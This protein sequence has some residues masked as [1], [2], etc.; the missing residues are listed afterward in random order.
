MSYVFETPRASPADS[1]AGGVASVEDIYAA[2]RDQMIFVDNSFATN[3]AMERAID[4]RNAEV[5][6]ATGFRP[7]NPYRRDFTQ[8]MADPANRTE[9]AGLGRAVAAWQQ[10]V[11][12]AAARIPDQSVAERLNRSIEGDAIHIAR[13][14]D[15]KLSRLM[16]SRPGFSKYLPA[17]GGGVTGSLRDPMTVT[18]LF[19]GGGPGAGRTIAA[20]LLS[21]A[22]R[23]AFVNAGTE[24]A[25]QPLVQAWRE[26]AGLDHGLS[27]ALTNIAFA[28]GF[29]G[30]FGAGGQA[31][32][33]IGGKLAGRGLEAAGDAAASDARVAEP[34][35]R[36]MQG[37][38][39]AARQT[40]PEIREAL[41]AAQRGALDH[42]ETL[43]HLDGTRPPAISAEVHDVAV[44]AAHRAIETET[45]PVFRA[46]PAQVERVTRAIVG[47]E[48]QP[49]LDKALS[50][51]E[52][53]KAKG[54]LVDDNGELVAIGAQDLAKNTARRGKADRRMQLD[55]AREAAEEAGYIGRAGEMQ[56][57]SVAD[58][59]DAIDTELRGQPVYSRADIER[60]PD[61]GADSGRMAE[62]AALERTVAEIAGHAGPGIDDA[63]LRE[64]AELSMRDGLEPFDALESVLTRAESPEAKAAVK[65]S[66]S[67]DPL[68]GWDDA[69]LERLS[70]GRGDEPFADP[71]SPFDDPAT[72]GDEFA[73]SPADLK[74]YG[75]ALIPDEDGNVVT[76]A[77]FMDH[78]GDE[79][80]LL[81]VVKA[82]R[83]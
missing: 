21:A 72:I 14:A 79:D 41:P 48:V 47:E 75:D 34:V 57:T 38:I 59:L 4:E 23:E 64:A 35:R 49:A 51:V 77:R 55:M 37:D 45:P 28:A 13:Q 15:E 61:L 74:L 1:F 44:T 3:A 9:D 36:A 31:L 70:A 8:T 6:S 65:A 66:R 62:R 50:L 5:F 83:A 29:G 32:G 43:E 69:E 39:A 58:L 68:P 26:K 25:M 80:E 46:D 81:S 7:D 71:A 20:R 33:E 40:L 82:C 53:L 12:D 78:L 63:I 16:A 73:I 76:L 11:S 52:F 18:S 54:G 27:E 19:I 67:G 2:A 30:V 22:A 56:V 42:A 24:A 60:A 17:L 10:S